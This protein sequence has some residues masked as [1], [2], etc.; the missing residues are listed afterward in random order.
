MNCVSRFF[1]T[2]LL[3]II[4]IVLSLSNALAAKLTI[5]SGVKEI[6]E[7][8]FYGDNSI[9]EVVLPEGIE[10]IG[11]RAFAESSLTRINL[12]DSLVSIGENALGTNTSITVTATEGSDAYNWAVQNGYIEDETIGEPADGIWGTCAWDLSEDGILTIHSGTGV[13]TQGTSPWFG[14]RKQIKSI[15]SDGMVVLPADSSS[16][17]DG[18][19]NCTS[20]QIYSFNTNNVINMHAMF[21][22]CAATHWSMSS[23]STSKVTDMSSM[24]ENCTN[25]TYQA[26]YSFDTSSVQDMNR[27]FASCGKMTGVS[28]IEKLDTSSVTNM[29]GMFSNCTSLTTLNLTT[30]DTSSVRDMSEMFSGCSNLCSL[31]LN[32]LDTSN[33]LNFNKMFNNCSG[34]LRLDLSSFNTKE[35]QYMTDMFSGC[36]AMNSITLGVDFTFKGKGVDILTTLP[37]RNWYSALANTSF[38]EQYIAENRNGIVDTYNIFG[39]DDGFYYRIDNDTYCT[40]MGYYGDA[41]E[42]IIPKKAPDGHIVNQIGDNAFNNRNDLSGTIIIPETITTIGNN[43]FNCCYGFTGNLIIPGSV[44]TIGNRAFY[45]CTGLKGTLV[46]QPGV[47]QI[48]EYAF[49]GSGFTGDLVIPGSI[50]TIGMYAFNQDTGFNGTLII[51]SGVES[52]GYSA[53]G[54]CTNFHG[55]LVLPNSVVSLDEHAFEKIGCDGNLTISSGLTKIPIYCFAEAKMTGDLIIPEGIT[56]IENYA[57]YDGAYTGHLVLPSTLKN[58]N[59]FT[60]C[61]FTGSLNL[62]DGLQTIQAGAFDC[63]SGFT[64]DLIIPDSVTLVSG[65]AFADCRGFNGHLVLSNS[66][67]IIEGCSFYRCWGLTGDLII[68][69]GVTEIHRYAFSDCW[70]FNGAL[71]LPLSLN[72]IE[73]RAFQ[74]CNQLTGDLIIPDGVTKIEDAAFA[75]CRRLNS[76]V[77]IPDT[78]NDVTGTPF[79]ATQYYQTMSLLPTLSYSYASSMISTSALSSKVSKFILK[80]NSY[81]H[82]HAEEHGFTPYELEYIDASGVLR[83]GEGWV[84]RWRIENGLGTD[85]VTHHTLLAIYLDGAN[86]ADGTIFTYSSTGNGYDFPWLSEE[87]GYSRSDFSLITI[88]GTATNPLYIIADMFK[89]YDNVRQVS[90]DYVNGFG[91]SAFENCT[92]LKRVNGF[93]AVLVS[94]GDKAFKNCTQLTDV[95]YSRSGNNGTFWTQDPVS[96]VSIGNEA[97][98][99]TALEGITLYSSVTTIADNAFSGCDELTIFCEKDSVAHSYAVDHNIPFMFINSNFPHE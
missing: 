28:N 85:G 73:E 99:N 59:G 70:G 71:S 9:D 39:I 1:R 78:V 64:G 7:E 31:S 19:Q 17:F 87:Y 25:L 84:L 76:M 80:K 49:S 43:A 50:Q 12:P 34:L 23:F 91:G 66:L 69:D 6:E 5:P 37:L 44:Q 11:A 61:K 22:A 52:I 51:Q 81:S 29:S 65:W 83:S 16:L 8:A 35:A 97:F 27:M 48:G 24:F 74:L 13:N 75:G 58:V 40:V 4:V 72:I 67:T 77:Y 55:D 62:P 42:I 30:F 10:R 54:S 20:I 33:V 15:V 60:K 95:F 79:S 41:L 38:T 18:F 98:R 2:S 82:L 88:T 63:C 32:G 46:I 96:L 14:F 94:I 53:F 26:F 89:D 56:D 21:R 36:S 3:F 90:T 93:D 86:A 47:K 92:S 45:G 57:F 68:P